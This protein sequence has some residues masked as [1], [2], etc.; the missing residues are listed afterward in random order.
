MHILACKRGQRELPLQTD[1]SSGP[2][3]NTCPINTSKNNDITLISRQ[4]NKF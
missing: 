1:I 2:F 4:F 3:S